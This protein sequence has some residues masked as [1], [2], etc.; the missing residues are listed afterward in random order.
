MCPS[1]IEIGSKT[2]EK[3]SAQTLR[4][5]GVGRRTV[6]RGPEGGGSSRNS[7]ALKTARSLSAAADGPPEADPITRRRRGGHK[8]PHDVT[9][10]PLQ[11]AARYFG[12]LP[13]S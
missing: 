6:G 9:S 7:G 5:F 13:A 3:N 1:L 2:A 4:V 12:P 10:H 8:T 11:R